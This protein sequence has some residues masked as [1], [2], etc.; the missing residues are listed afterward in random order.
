MAKIIDERPWLWATHVWNMFDF[1]CDARDEGGIKGRNNKG[2]V[3]MD[4]KICKDS[5]YVYKAYW[6]SDPFVHLA[7]SGYSQRTGEYTDVK[8]YSNQ[9]CISL[10]IDLSLIHI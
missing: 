8:V 2:L 7:G 3:T 5:F 10:Y 9:P 6:S 4:R 1:G